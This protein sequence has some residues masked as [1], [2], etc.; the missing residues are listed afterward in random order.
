MYSLDT[1]ENK[2]QE[3]IILTQKED[4]SKKRNKKSRKKDVK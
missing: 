1:P 4:V 2:G 3:K